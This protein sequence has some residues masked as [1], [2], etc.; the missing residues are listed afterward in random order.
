MCWANDN[1]Q[2]LL[3]RLIV[4]LF[5]VALFPGASSAYE[6]VSDDTL[7]SIPD[8]GG[9]FEIHSG[10]LLAPI[11][12]PRV[13]GTPGS[14]T[15]QRHFVEFFRKYL[16]D[17]RIDW[18]NST[19]KVPGPGDREIPFT[20]LVFTRDPPWAQPGDVGRL[21]LAAHYDSL[22]N[23]EGFIGAIDSAAPCAMLLHVA[24]SIDAALTKKWKHME[25]NGDAGSGLEEDKGVQIILLDGEEAWETWSSTDSLYGARAL[26]ETWDSQR[27]P[28]MSAYQTPIQAINMFLLVDLLGA[29]NPNIPS[30]FESTHWAYQAMAKIEHRMRVVGLLQTTSA[31][32]WFSESKKVPNQFNRGYIEDDHIPFLIRGVPILHIIPTPFPKVWHNM[33]DDG[34]H[35]DIETVNDWAKIVTGFAAEWMEL[36]GFMESPRQALQP[37]SGEAHYR[38]RNEL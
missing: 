1:G 32:P 12:I 28:S 7:R 23:P 5:L 4:L 26:A 8:G 20:S 17:W 31:K 24:R 33:D 34:E 19:S 30:Y 2:W 29:P 13:P 3:A 6:T 22:Y 15:A 16:P 14:E 10:A 18:H 38:D 9:D 25:D 11:L 36:E 35:L 21:T 27:Y 37:K